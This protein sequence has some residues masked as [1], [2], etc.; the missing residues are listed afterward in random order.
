MNQTNYFKNLSVP[1][2]C[3]DI[4]MDT[5]AYNEIDD[6]F[7]ISY[8]IKHQEKFKI[9]G[10]CAAPFLNARVST[11]SEGM[12]KSYEEILN[13]LSLTNNDELKSIVFKGSEDYLKDEHTPIH[14]DASAFIAN[15]ANEYNQ[16]RPLYIIA[17][18]AITNIASAI[19]QNPEMIN[20]CVVIWLGG[21]AI[22]CN[23]GAN[24]FNMR[25]DIAAARVVF[26]SGIPLVML[27]CKGVVD[28]LLTSKYE[29]E[30][31]LS[32]KNKLCD[33]LF[34]H[35]VEEAESYAK[36]RPW[37]RVIWDISAVAWLLNE[38]NRYM[39]DKLI[40]C[41]VPEYDKHYAFD[42]NRRLIKYVYEINRDAIFEDLFHSLGE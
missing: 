13:L 40:S 16:E 24:E 11:V 41:P 3:I 1:N 12:R 10:F 34:L 21:H 22:H 19:L 15:H 17:I 35:T 9:K 37:T 30:H 27:P 29:L 2:G 20:R 26:D 14:S 7:A 6:Q 36:D 18:G 42:D 38:N 31:W 4:I 39:K 33:Y 32:G 25:Q 28:R 23:N 5:D 8:L